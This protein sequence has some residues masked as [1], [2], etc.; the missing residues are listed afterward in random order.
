M[1]RLRMGVSDVARTRFGYSPLAEVVQSRYPLS[2]GRGPPL[3]RP[4]WEATRDS[5]R[6]VDMALLA[7]V[8]PARAYVA[9]F[10]F[11]AASQPGGIDEQLRLVAESDVAGIRADVA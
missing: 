3:H 6:G 8:L 1:I 10:L 5:L 4:W 9:D 7:A 11:S 2:S